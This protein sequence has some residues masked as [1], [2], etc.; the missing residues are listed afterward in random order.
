MNTKKLAV[1]VSHTHWDRAWYLPYQ[2]YRLALVRL[3]DQLLDLFGNPNRFPNFMLDGQM[4]PI[5]DYLENRPEKRQELIKLVESGRLTIGPWFCLADE[6]LVSPEALVRNLLYGIQLGD[7]YGG[8]ARIGYVPD[9]FG[10]INQLP[11]IL[12]GFGIDSALFWRGMG[13]EA[14]SLGD[15]FF[16]L[17]PEG[18]AVLAVHLRKGYFNVSN[19]GYPNRFGVPDPAAFDLDR[20]VNQLVDTAKD[21]LSTSKSGA[22]L[23]MNGFDHAPVQLNLPEIIQEA[24]FSQEAIHFEHSSILEFLERVRKRQSEDLPEYRGEF[25]RSRYAFGL[26]GVYSSRMYLQQANHHAQLSLEQFAEPLS[27]WSWLTGHPYPTE[28]LHLAW[29]K[30]LQNHPH[31]DICGCSTD[32]VHQE[33]MVRFQQVRQI[34]DPLVEAGMHALANRIQP[35]DTN[36][37]RFFLYNPLPFPRTETLVLDLYVAQESPLPEVF[38]LVDP[39]EN[40]LQMQILDVDEV[41]LHRVNQSRPYQHIRAAV[42]LEELP[43]C[44]YRVLTAKPGP[45]ALPVSTP[46]QA[47]LQ[48]NGMENQHLQVAIQPDGTLDILEKKTGKLYTGLL[49]FEDQADI[50]DEY[51]FSPSPQPAKF[52]TRNHPA[53][54]T[55]IT[56]GPLLISYQIQHDF[57]IPASIDPDRQRRSSQLQVCKLTTRVTL[58]KGTPHLEIQTIFE[59]HARDH[60]L[61]VLFPTSIQTDQVYSEGHFWVNERSID[62][63]EGED[64]DQPPA[65]TRHQRSFVDLTDGSAGLA[66]FNRGLPE[67]EVLQQAGGNTIALTLL[68]AVN[69]LSRGDLST[70]P[71]GHAGPPEV[72]T[73]DAQC[74]GEHVFEYAIAPHAGNWLQVYPA[75][76]CY[77]SSAI[78]LKSTLED[79]LSPDAAP[80]QPDPPQERNLDSYLPQ[81]LSFLSLEPDLLGLSAV[82]KAE[83]SETLILRLYNP[84]NQTRQACLRF[85]FPLLSAEET[86]LNEEPIQPIP[87]QGDRELTFPLDG[88]E[89]KTIAVQIS[90]EQTNPE[91]RTQPGQV[92]P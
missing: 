58:R 82:K 92:Q 47:T 67:Y 63:P 68:R 51:D 11:Q 28:F 15:E 45:A 86:T 24:N 73:P 26:Q 16:W 46:L 49:S 3:I 89:I 30:L 66:I 78:A 13:D 85:G 43:G 80:Y 18:T 76:A 70:R 9:S 91:N 27:S 48:E 72:A 17:A 22:V 65:P 83:N 57:A 62:R 71:G 59:N 1:L 33:N 39:E 87:V 42:F 37:V 52:S 75:A 7:Q 64:W 19:L 38:H 88:G 69:R 54:I 14:K 25:N 60:R 31:D 8:A 29:T 34:T 77:Q 20:A 81:E 5:L 41:Y 90:R 74:L 36:Q 23:L 61:R 55:K 35:D 44:G 10:H 53:Q 50:G 40:P 21:L 79:R 84:S 32:P 4:L 12:Q 6:Y 2:T 56:E